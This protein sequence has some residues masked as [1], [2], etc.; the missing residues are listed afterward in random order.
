MPG[1]RRFRSSTRPRTVSGA[2]KGKDSHRNKHGAFFSAVIDFTIP[3]DE[4]GNASA[5]TVTYSLPAPPIVFPVAT[6][7]N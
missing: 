2:V 5:D 4:A 7:G 1:R 3:V 6:E